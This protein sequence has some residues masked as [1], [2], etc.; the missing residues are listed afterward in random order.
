ML[1]KSIQM[2]AVPVLTNLMEKR[3]ELEPT[4]PFEVGT[5]D[6]DITGGKVPIWADRILFTPVLS[7]AVACL[8]VVW[9][10]CSR[11][12]WFGNVAG[13]DAAL[14]RHKH[15]CS[16]VGAQASVRWVFLPVEL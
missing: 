3:A 15:G 16:N 11:S 13:Y 5:D 1:R 9:A 12:V 10:L 4:Y 7:C 2:R 8:Q 14:L 6:Y